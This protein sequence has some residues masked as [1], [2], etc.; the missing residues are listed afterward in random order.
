MIQ[1]ATATLVGTLARDPELRFTAGGAVL[2][3]AVVSEYERDG[4]KYKSTQKATLWGHNAEEFF[5]TE[6]HAGDL[7]EV[8]G[9]LR[10]RKY[11]KNGQE[12]WV[13]EVVGTAR[14][15][16]ASVKQAVAKPDATVDS[17]IPF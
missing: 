14:L 17:D 9:D 6:P 8:T 2:N 10:N 3:I 16:N 7:I 5:A 13:T 15:L 11:E 12:V 4:R 1:G